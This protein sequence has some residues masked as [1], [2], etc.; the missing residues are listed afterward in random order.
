M[1]TTNNLEYN[2]VDDVD[3]FSEHDD[4]G[5]SVSHNVHALNLH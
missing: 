1:I 2:D 4:L 5:S 3:E